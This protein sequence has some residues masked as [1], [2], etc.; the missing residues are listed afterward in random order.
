MRLFF[1][2]FLFCQTGRKVTG[3]VTLF[4]FLN[5]DFESYNSPASAALGSICGFPQMAAFCNVI[6]KCNCEIP[7]LPAGSS[8]LR[9]MRLPPLL[10]HF[11]FLFV[12]NHCFAVGSGFVDFSVQA[13]L[14]VQAFAIVSR[15]LSWTVK[16][17]Q[18]YE[19]CVWDMSNFI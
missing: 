13:V 18:M 3:R 9:E 8:F 5:I 1:L 17:L 2:F 10:D 11:I 7:V 16:K 6:I 12:H 14:Y 15:V 4:F 19:R